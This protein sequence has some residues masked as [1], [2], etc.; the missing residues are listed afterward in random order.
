MTLLEGLL[1]VLGFLVV[2]LVLGAAGLGVIAW[3]DRRVIVPWVVRVGQA[4]HDRRNARIR[5][6]SCWF[7]EDEPTRLLLLEMSESGWDVG[8]ARERWRKRRRGLEGA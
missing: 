8:H 7:S 6:D 4:E 5:D 3:F 2:V 1:L